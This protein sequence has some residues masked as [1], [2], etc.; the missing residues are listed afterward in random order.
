[1]YNSYDWKTALISMVILVSAVLLYQY[2]AQ[3][4]LAA[5]YWVVVIAVAVLNGTSLFK[6]LYRR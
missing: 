4:T 5:K 1:M 3:E 6:S 2:V